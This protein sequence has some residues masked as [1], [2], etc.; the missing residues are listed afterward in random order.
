MRPVFELL[1]LSS[2]NSASIIGSES[3]FAA[4]M[5]CMA[6]NNP[7]TP[8]QPSRIA[9]LKDYR[10]ITAWCFE[11]SP[12][13]ITPVDLAPMTSAEPRLQDGGEI[14]KAPCDIPDQHHELY[15]VKNEANNTGPICLSYPCQL[16]IRGKNLIASVLDRI[17]VSQRHRCCRL[18]PLK[19][20]Q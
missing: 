19:T 2:S 17:V 11:S 6:A 18:L 16:V 5:Y 8:Y 20:T 14:T 1:I 12:G 7:G 4:A 10:S 13:R 3:G 15:N 9:P